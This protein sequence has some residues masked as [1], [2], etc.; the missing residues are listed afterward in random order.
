VDA[1]LT[2][3]LCCAQIEVIRA[4]VVGVLTLADVTNERGIHLTNYATGCIFHYDKDFPQDSGI[5][6][7]EADTPNFLGSYY[8]RTKV[9]AA[10]RV[11]S[12][13]SVRSAAISLSL[14][15]LLRKCLR[16]L[17]IISSRFVICPAEGYCTNFGGSCMLARS[18][19]WCTQV[20]THQRGT[21]FRV[22]CVQA[23]VEGL[24]KEFPNTLILRVRMPIVA[25]L[26]YPRNFVTKIIKYEKVRR[27]R[28]P[29][30]C[31]TC[32]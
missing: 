5:G 24:L 13:R 31:R 3:P 12:C 10:A 14:I 4:N 19:A 23:L 21:H 27:S 29:G 9:R 7:K 30:T 2:A 6:F 28:M 18:P 25:D 22:V 1:E 15:R 32:C 16:Q 20:A 26:V 8:S 11:K 17:R